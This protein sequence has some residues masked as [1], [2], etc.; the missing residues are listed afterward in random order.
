MKTGSNEAPS[1]VR[2]SVIKVADFRGVVR[3]GRSPLTPQA[4]GGGTGGGGALS[5]VGIVDG[6]GPV[7]PCVNVF[8]IF[9]GSVWAGTPSPSSDDVVGA[10]TNILRGPY[11]SALLQYRGVGHGRLV[12]QATV[13][14]SNP[15]ASFSEDQVIGFIQD[16]IDNVTVPVPD[17]AGPILYAV[18]MPE[19]TK[20]SD[21]RDSGAHYYFIRTDA[22]DLVDIDVDG[23]AGDADE[24]LDNN[25]PSDGLDVDL[26]RDNDIGY[27]VWVTND[28]TLDGITAIFSHELVEVCSDPEGTAFSIVPADPNAAN[29]IGDASCGCQDKNGRVNGILVQKY[30]SQ[31]DNACV[32][33]VMEPVTPFA[34]SWGSNRLDIFGVGTD[35]AMFHKT[36]DGSGWRPSVTGWERQGGAFTSPPAVVA[37]GANRLDVFGLGTDGSMFH[38]AWDGDAWQPSLAGWEPQGGVFTSPPSVVSWGPGRLD[39]FGLNLDH[40][41]SHKA[42]DGN[43]W[44]SEWEDLGGVFGSPPVAVSWDTDRLDIFGL[45]TDGSML[46]RAWDGN[47]WQPPSDVW[48]NLGGT[49]ISQPAVV[50]WES[51]R[52]DVFAIWTDGSMRHKAWDVNGWTDWENLGG[53]FTSPPAVV[54]WGKNRLDIFGV[55]TEGAMYHKAWGESGWW[56]SQL[57]WE[58]LGGVFSSPPRV[59]SWGAERLDVFGL[60]STRSMY[61]KAWDG[62]KWQ[63]EWEDLAGVFAAP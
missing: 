30:W 8:L 60:G 46:H 29:E 10:V 27:Y 33:P 21:P 47:S 40:A 44:Q 56:P 4:D 52:L 42:F 5:G 63:E 61:H 59:V 16:S 11:M 38:K 37:W 15:P 49:F 17:Q 14:S 55:G 13:T 51:N 23:N 45:T 7:L 35:G 53:T 19:G 48:E 50:S 41:V 31:R 39:V 28:G 62:Q 34:V 6:H 43:G 9:W 2:R 25:S 58:P 22:D 1:P 57:D 54:A 32:A 20:Y 36:W 12:G 18:I 3:A 24:H 26:P